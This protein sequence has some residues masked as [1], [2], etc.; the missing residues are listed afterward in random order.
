MLF[1]TAIAFEYCRICDR[2]ISFPNK[3]F[4]IHRKHQGILSQSL[5]VS[6]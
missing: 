3:G 4:P 2:K 5:D 6:Y 1:Q